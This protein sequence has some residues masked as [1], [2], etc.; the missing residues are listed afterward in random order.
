MVCYRSENESLCKILKCRTSTW[1]GRYVQNLVRIVLFL[2]K[3]SYLRD[4]KL[5]FDIVI[6]IRYGACCKINI[7]DLKI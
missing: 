5:N 1:W 4:V 7:F 2:L 3:A 6:H